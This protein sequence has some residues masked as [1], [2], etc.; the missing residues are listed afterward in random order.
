MLWNI[1][2]RWNTLCG[3]SERKH[4]GS[5]QRAAKVLVRRA[6]HWLSEQ[7]NIAL[8]DVLNYFNQ[9]QFRCNFGKEWSWWSS[10]TLNTFHT[11]P[12]TPHI[13]LTLEHRHLSP[14]TKNRFAH[15][16]VPNS[17]TNRKWLRPPWYKQCPIA[18]IFFILYEYSTRE[19]KNLNS[20]LSPSLPFHHCSFFFN[21]IINVWT[22]TC[23]FVCVAK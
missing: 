19:H 11:L 20:S 23:E 1:L 16:L 8:N 9:I 10:H 3:S 14:L 7:V 17:F 22:A 13:C 15:F 2:E 6:A 12:Q 21:C 5:L 4:D 18:Y